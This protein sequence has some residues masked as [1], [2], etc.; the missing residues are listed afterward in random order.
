M[1]SEAPVSLLWVHKG[2]VEYVCVLGIIYKVIYIVLSSQTCYKPDV[3]H[4]W[5]S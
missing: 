4:I 3:G 5:L 1:A 2:S